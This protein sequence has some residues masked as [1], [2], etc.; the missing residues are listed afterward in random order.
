MKLQKLIL[1]FAALTLLVGCKNNN[2]K[3]PKETADP[4]PYLKDAYKDYFTI[5]ATFNEYVF[6][7]KVTPHFNSMTAENAMKWISVHP[8]LDT[9]D[10]KEADRHVAYAKENNL[11]LRGHALVWH[12]EK[13][14]PPEVFASNDKETVL[15]IEKEHIDTVVRHFSDSVYCWDVCNEVIDDGTTELKED[16]S[17]TYRQ[18]EWYNICGRDFIKEAYIEADETLKELGIRDK[19]KL[20]YNDYDNTKPVKRAKTLA[21]LQWLLDENVP[22]DGV[23]M[24]CH[25]HLG[26]FDMKQLEDSIV[27]YSNLGLDVQI[28]EFDVDIYDRTSANLTDYKAYADVPQ[29]VLDVQA[30]IYGRAFEIFR[31]HHD[32]I[33][34][35]TFWGVS[36]ANTYMN[37]NPDYGQLTNYPYVFDVFDKP[38]PAFYMITDF[39]KHMDAYDPY[40]SRKNEDVSNIYNGN[41]DEFHISSWY[42]SDYGQIDVREKENETEVFYMKTFGYEYTGIYSSVMGPL[43][44]FSYINFVAKG[45]PGRNMTL[46]MYYGSKEDE[47][48]NVLGNDVAFSLTEDYTIHTLKVKGNMTSRL[49]LLKRVV[50]MPEVGLSSVNGTFYIK[51]V[52]F[53][54][55]IPANGY[56]EN[57]GVDTGDTSVM[58]NG[59]RTEGWTN[60]SLYPVANNGVGIR[61]NSAAEWGYIEKTIDIPEGDNGLYFQ[62]QNILE[63]DIPSVTVIHLILRGDVKEHVSE[64]VEYEYDIFYEAPIYTYD[65]TKNNEVQ[66]DENGITTLELSLENALESIGEHHQELGYRLTLLIESH[67][68]DYMKYLYSTNG[69]MVIKDVHTYKGD[70]D[71]EYYS[72]TG[73]G[74]YVLNKKEGVDKNITYTNVSG[75]AYWPRISRKMVGTN[76]A[77]VITLV[78]RNNGE[79]TAKVAVHAGMI[80][81]DRSDSK[82]NYFYPLWHNRGLSGDYFDDGL[83]Y[84]IESGQSVTVTISVDEAYTADTDIID[85]IQFLIDN[86]YGDD[87]LRSG[88]IDIVSVN[89]A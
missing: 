80:N 41:Q 14:I 61:Y 3:K 2:N 11:G 52:Y 7:N 64:G 74:S 38:K 20:F 35:V 63:L 30:T 88:D 82:N 29:E 42:A 81:D 48:H 25:Y 23:G 43:A 62:F 68:D 1:C 31:K 39:Y 18:S 16:G 57:P 32:K 54:K 49:D 33:S 83:S 45:D 76:H 69:H 85:T 77:S 84:D 65:L 87:T 37:N 72:L 9:Y 17:N 86:C 34:N 4:V 47:T 71:V 70:F 26:S 13:S 21:M 5:G 6:G 79:N 28:T 44:D 51:D 66:A 55:D 40:A 36:D 75:S 12:N 53:S 67:P 27:A 19:V 89:I 60:Y 15:S 10:F 46:R 78:I 24:Q 50:V 59:W 8:S 56:L 22:I 58:V 73:E